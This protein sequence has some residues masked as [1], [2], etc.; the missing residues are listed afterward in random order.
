M[1]WK[2]FEESQTELPE[3]VVEKMIEGFSSATMELVELGI[4]PKSEM[5]R[6]TTDKLG[7][8][9]QFKVILLSRHLPDYSFT[10]F[11]FGYNVSLYPVKVLIT[12]SILEE[13]ISKGEGVSTITSFDE[14]QKFHKAI[15]LVFESK[16]F[17]EVVSGLMKIAKK[18]KLPF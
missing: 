13:L 14:E 4:L 18:K 10:V 11:E 3:T 12:K 2:N 16:R 6:L 5:S 9:F 8:R 15:E 17:T 1:N 7:T